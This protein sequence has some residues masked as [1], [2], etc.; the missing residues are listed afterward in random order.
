MRQNAYAGQCADCGVEVGPQG[1]FRIGFGEDGFTVCAE[2]RPAPPPRGEHEGWHTGPLA[3]L[4]FETTGVDPWSDRIVSYAALGPDARD[5]IGRVNPQVPIPH[6]PSAIHGLRDADVAAAPSPVVALRELSAWVDDLVARRVPLV[7]FNAA[8][9]LTVLRTELWRYRLSQPRW[10][11]LLVIDPFVVD[12][13]IE[14]GRLGSRRL[15]DVA[16]YYGIAIENA[17]DAACDARV[18]RDVAIELGARH[19]RVIRG[20]ARLAMAQQRFWAARR[21]MDFNRFAM[22]RGRRLEPIPDWPFAPAP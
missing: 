5:L 16:D 11:A 10:D 15:V 2:H 20:E 22:R 7:V 3:S 17:H 13:G 4:D 14:R 6:K 18:A 8:F 21:T 19:R 1:G 12:Y 9:D